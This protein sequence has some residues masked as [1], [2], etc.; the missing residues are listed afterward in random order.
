M[1]SSLIAQNQTQSAAGVTTLSVS[2][3]ISSGSSELGCI[4]YVS[5]G[6]VSNMNLAGEALTSINSKWY[7][8]SGVTNGTK[9]L[10]VN[11]TAST[12]NVRV[13]AGVFADVYQPS[14]FVSFLDYGQACSASGPTSGAMQFIYSTANP[15]N[16][17]TPSTGYRVVKGLFP[18]QSTDGTFDTTSSCSGSGYYSNTPYSYQAYFDNTTGTY[19]NICLTS[20]GYS[21]S[22][23]NGNGSDYAG[24]VFTFG[25]NSSIGDMIAV[26]DGTGAVISSSQLIII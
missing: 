26:V 15:A 14:P 16:N 18:F 8:L 7:Y 19:E 20:A 24:R 11:F 4:V 6:G 25:T 9:T 17:T 13:W 3:D 2:L 10:T 1:A 5:S 21:A 22:V 23:G 12:A